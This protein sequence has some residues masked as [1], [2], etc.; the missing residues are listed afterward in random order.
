MP[1][2]QPMKIA[3]VD[4]PWSTCTLI[5]GTVI[6]TKTVFCDIALVIDDNGNVAVDPNG[7]AQ[8]AIGSQQV[9]QIKVAPTMGDKQ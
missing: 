1:T 6:K 9:T 3:S 7:Q 2:F 8:F 5:D 4:E